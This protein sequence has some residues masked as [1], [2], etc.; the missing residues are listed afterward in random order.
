MRAHHD[1]NHGGKP[2]CV[3]GGVAL[4]EHTRRETIVFAREGVVTFM[5]VQG[6]V[7]VPR[8]SR[9]WNHA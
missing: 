1:E 3:M 2:N 5:R 8:P 6:S 9:A 7:E 4:T